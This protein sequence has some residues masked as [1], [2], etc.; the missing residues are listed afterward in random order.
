M[1]VTHAVTHPST[2][3]LIEE[4][5]GSPIA[6][7]GTLATPPTHE[8]SIANDGFWPDVDLA[9]LRASTRLTGNVTTERLRASAI[10]AMLDVNTQLVAFKA[11]R[12]GEGWDSAADVG[13]TIAG[14][15]ALVHRYLRA[16]VSTVQ[17]DIAE[18]YRDWDNTR[19]GDYRG[20]GENDSADD[21][22]RNARWAVADILGRPRNVVELL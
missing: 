18:K 22:R 17:A 13:E 11:A 15:T 3:G 21:F 2:A 6:N 20:Q 10:E 12:I 4:P 1:R 16:V 19:A 14:A 8:G 5:M 9:M 7:G